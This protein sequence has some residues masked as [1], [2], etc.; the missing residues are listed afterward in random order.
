[1]EGLSYKEVRA[2]PFVKPDGAGERFGGIRHG[3]W[4]DA[5]MDVLD[6]RD[7]DV[8]AHRY[9]LSP[10]GLNM[11]AGLI[12]QPK[13]LRALYPGARWWLG[14]TNPNDRHT[15]PMVYAGAVTPAGS[16]VVFAQRRAANRTNTTDHA[17]EFDRHLGWWVAACRCTEPLIRALR[18]RVCHPPM[19]WR[20]VAAAARGGVV[21]WGRVG[22]VEA[23]YPK[24]HSDNTAWG[25]LVA[26]GAVGRRGGPIV[27]VPHYEKFFDIVCKAYELERP[28]IKRGDKTRTIQPDDGAE[29]S[30][31][32]A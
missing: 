20:C 12:I 13:H 3:E 30:V 8:V 15:A 31:A 16:L 28:E 10:N 27:A 22:R 23:A 25:M 21:P 4:A 19:F 29:A 1:M 5:A 9:H 32:S 18:N 11:L 17:R 14:V 26:Y 6:E 7:W 2:L 24:N